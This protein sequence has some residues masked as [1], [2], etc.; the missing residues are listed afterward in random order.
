MIVGSYKHVDLLYALFLGRLPENNFV[1]QEN[2]GRPVIDIA[3]AMIGGEEF[4]Q[5]VIER[6]ALHKQLPHRD[7]P[8]KLLPEA[9]QLI[10]EAGLAPPRPG[11]LVADWQTVLGYVLSTMPCRGFLEAMHGEPGRQFL[12]WLAGHGSRE[13]PD[14]T[15]SAAAA[16]ER[17]TLCEPDIVSGGEII[18]NTICRGWIIDRNNVDAILHVRLRLNGGTAKIVAADEFRRDVQERYG[19][20]GRAGFTIH[21]DQLPDAPYLNRGTVQVEELSR[22]IIVLPGQIVEFSPLPAMRVEA[23]LREALSRVR[24]CLDRLQSPASL[25]SSDRS[26]KFIRAV[27]QLRTRVAKPKPARA[28]DE[29]SKLLGALDGLEQRLPKLERGQDWALPYYSAVRPL[30]E[31]VAPPPAIPDPASFSVI[32][33][34]DGRVPKAAKD[35]LASVLAQTHGPCEVCLLSG[36]ETPIEPLSAL[37]KVEIL[38]LA[39]DQPANAAVNGLAARLTGS[40]LLVLDA[41]VAL[42]PE[43]LAWLAAAIKNTNAPI[44]Y[45]DAEAARQPRAG[46]GRLEPRFRPAFDYDL[47]LQRN[48]IGDTFCIERQAYTILGGLS[49]DPAL[50]A[51]H[52]LLLRAHARFGRSGFLHLPLPLVRNATFLS[53]VD[54][55][56]VGNDDPVRRTVQCYL[57]HIGSGARPLAH[58]DAYGRPVPNVLQIDWP[59]DAERRLSVIVPTRDRA[60]MVFALISSLRRHAAAW[61]RVE[62]IVVV[63]GKPESWSRSTFAEIENT[64]SRVRVVYHAVDFNWAGINNY[65]VR[66]HTGGALLLFMNDDMI[67]LTRN[68]DQRVRSQLAR[69][70]IG[71]IGGRLLYPN[72]AIQHAGIAF[73]EGAMTAHEAMGDEAGDGLY[74]DRTLLVHEVG[75]VTGALFGC[76]RSLFDSLGGFDAQRYAVTSSDADFC[77]RMRLANKAVIYDP[78][79]TWIHYESISRGFDA[80]D[81]KRQWRADAEHELWRSRFS[82]ID[83]VDLSVNPHFA[84]SRRPFETFHRLDRKEIELWLSAQ[85]ARHRHG[86]GKT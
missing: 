83:L 52:D 63:N 21:L 54:A 24:D 23:E 2:I 18:A 10:A 4:G 35:T 80:H 71:V 75:A 53:P 36:S 48:Y 17:P 82:E 32:I 25:E 64:F 69:D 20:E 8:L 67:C 59:E 1:R 40:H 47:L 81:L 30:V 14:A 68:W 15:G 65:A 42:A 27:R 78:S 79:L 58:G 13:R 74:L 44:I 51:R 3:K 7:L 49:V 62:I 57:D 33:V 61:D 76:R 41:G 22:G 66:E 50:D 31:M 5:S 77:V 29:L 56:R 73:G 28:D 72:G 16:D 6:F 70:E 60:D 45:T 55:A 11:M 34:D 19:G 39:P 37:E 86:A 43:A 85:R 84:R 12:E 46:T 38:G 9:L 26:R